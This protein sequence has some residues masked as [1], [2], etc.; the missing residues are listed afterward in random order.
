MLD[1]T[2]WAVAI[3]CAVAIVPIVEIQ[4]M[5]ERIIRKNKQKKIASY[6]NEQDEEVEQQN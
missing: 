6:S 1:S 4:K 3:G 2:G 5:V